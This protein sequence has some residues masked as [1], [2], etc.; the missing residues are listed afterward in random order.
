MSDEK[1][2]NREKEI[3]QYQVKSYDAKVKFW[4]GNLHQQMRW[5]GESGLDEYAVF[6]KEWL[7]EAKKIE[8]KIEQILE[9]VVK[10]YWRNYWDIDKIREALKR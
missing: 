3:K 5:N 7:E 10:R 8:P 6:S 9:D 1:N 2:S 4:S